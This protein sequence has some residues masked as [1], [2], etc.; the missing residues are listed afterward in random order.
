[1][2]PFRYSPANRAA[3]ITAG[4]AAEGVDGI[5]KLVA[6][7]LSV[8]SEAALFKAWSEPRRKI[9]AALD[10]LAELDQDDSVRTALPPGFAHSVA[11]DL[12]AALARFPSPPK[13]GQGPPKKTRERWFA[14]YLARLYHEASGK[15]PDKPN[16]LNGATRDYG[17]FNDFVRLAT[18]DTGITIGVPLVKEAVHEYAERLTAE[19]LPR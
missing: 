10:A 2:D 18:A 7:L 16:R 6:H 15:L 13:K 17:D 14:F 3:L 5:E 11:V 9:C 12:V 8:P 4:I 1:M 19:R